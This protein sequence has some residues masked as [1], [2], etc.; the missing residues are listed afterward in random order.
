MTRKIYIQ[1]L[2]R[3]LDKWNIH[4]NK[5]EKK[6]QTLKEETKIMFTE[7]LVDIRNLHDNVAEK[8][9][10]IKSGTKDT[11]INLRQESKDA[12]TKFVDAFSKANVQI[13]AIIEA[14]GK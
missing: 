6:T 5:L 8:L 3:K 11:W 4:L 1:K 12:R 7:K 10:Q 2:K 14:Q 9:E 13:G